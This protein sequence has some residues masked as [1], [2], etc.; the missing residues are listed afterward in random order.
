MAEMA[1]AVNPRLQITQFPD[2][3]SPENLDAFLEGV[4]LFVDGFDFFVL[5]IRRL[6]FSRCAELGIPAITAAPI[7]MGTNWL[8]F[9]PGGM[10]FEQ[11]FR[12]AGQS[13]PEQY[14]RFLM[15]LAP[16]GV[17]RRYLVDPSRVD[18]ER[19]VGP[20]TTMACQL[21]SG[22]VGVE[23]V[24][25]LLGRGDVQPA[26]T[27]H[28]FDPYVGVFRRTRLR[29]G[30]AGPAQRLKLAVARQIYL[31]A[32]AP[33]SAAA[34]APAKSTPLEQILQLARWA[35]SGDN[36]QPW[37]FEIRGDESVLV[38]FNGDRGNP[39]EYRNGE[40]SLLSLGM[41]L[42]TIRLAATA[43]GRTLEYDLEGSSA[44]SLVIS[45][46]LPLS[47]A[48]EPDPLH[49][50]ITTRSVHRR[51]LRTRKLTTAEKSSLEGALGPEFTV[52]WF[53]TARARWRIGRLGARVTDIRL[54]APELFHVHQRVI[55]WGNRHSKTGIPAGAVGLD[56][57]TLL[58]MRWAM[59]SWN[60]MH[61]LNRLTGT[62]LASA[63]L[64]L[65]P[66]L[67]CA[68][69]FFI[70]PADGT[71]G[72]TDEERLRA[73][74][75]IQRFWLTATKLGLAIQPASAVL[76]LAHHGSSGIPFTVD[77][78]LQRK[79]RAVA[80]SFKD[81]VGDNADQFLFAGRIGQPAPRLPGPRS[82]RLPLSELIAE[83]NS[84]ALR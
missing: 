28:L 69:F 17:H 81:I 13:E 27:H 83:P 31:R 61:R 38:R 8:I 21:C 79:T 45:A 49:S 34:P 60:R 77:Q 44:T 62:R 5:D 33:R 22:V 26:P 23:A 41:L 36:A 78:D 29:R 19:K 70:G 7:G 15:G 54:R 51:A 11:Y 43:H 25:L 10:S 58:V 68:G 50:Y 2:G 75:A 47:P 46:R 1:L 16:R 53:E 64:D 9:T 39:Y 55:D 56:R 12:L 71:G 14:L 67:R 4:D 76:M 84:S 74:A 48:V 24:K 32:R 18:I 80:Q 40:P 35:P 6:V 63:Q 72:L 59:Q 20:S 30:L 73:G 37:R 57:L 65:L 82:V 42:E 52:R 66:G 3:V